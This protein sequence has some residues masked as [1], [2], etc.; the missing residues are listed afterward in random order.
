MSAEAL[1]KI[2]EPFYTTRRGKGGSGL[3][4]YIV[5][6]LATVKLGGAITCSS[7]PEK[8]ARFILA[9]PA[10]AQTKGSPT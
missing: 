6:S 4:L 8:G 9:Y 1:A 3:G 7:E 5:F 2:F 10:D